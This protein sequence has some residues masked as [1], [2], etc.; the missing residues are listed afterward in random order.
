M[1]LKLFKSVR[2]VD[3]EEESDRISII[4][5]NFLCLHLTDSFTFSVI[6]FSRLHFFSCLNSDDVSLWFNDDQLNRCIIFYECI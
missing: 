4:T 3:Q 1:Q 2:K 6:V 5:I